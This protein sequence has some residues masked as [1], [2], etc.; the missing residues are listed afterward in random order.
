MQLL[1][2]ITDKTF[3]HGCFQASILIQEFVVSERIWL[4]FFIIHYLDENNEHSGENWCIKFRK[5]NT[6]EMK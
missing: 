4:L 3:S 2:K 5:W 6:Y 1:L